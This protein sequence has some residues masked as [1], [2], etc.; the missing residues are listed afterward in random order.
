PGSEIF[1]YTGDV[2]TFIAPVT[3]T[4]T[5]DA[6]GAK[7]GDVTTHY[8]TAGGLGGRASGDISL[9]AGQTIYIYV[10]GAGE[11]R[12]GDHPYPDCTYVAGGWNG[13]GATS[14]RGNSTPGGGASDVRIGGQTLNDRIIVAGGGGGGGWYGSL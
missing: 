6:Y 8:P 1:S 2:Q 5:I 13:G 10:G 4:Y 12:L 3:G 9:T 11:D 14:S 7:G